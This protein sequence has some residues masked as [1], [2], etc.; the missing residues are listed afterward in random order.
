LH[1]RHVKLLR[2]ALLGLIVLVL[3][4]VSANYWES[5]RR[6]SRIITEA[7]KLLGANALRSADSIEYSQNEKGLVRFKI[8]A[9]RLLETREGKSYLEGIEAFDFKPDGSIQN[10]IRSRQARYDREHKQALFSGDVRIKMGE[11]LELQTETLHYDMQANL[12][13][14]EDRLRLTSSDIVGS[15]K[16]MRYQHQP[17]FLE[18]HSEIDFTLKRT[19]TAK[20]GSSKEENVR[21]TAARAGYSEADQRLHFQGNASLESETDLLSGEELVATLSPDRKRITS[22]LCRG[23][24]Q[25]QVKDPSETRR[26]KGDQ[27]AFAINSPSGAL[28]RIDVEGRAVFS[29]KSQDT[30]QELRGSEIHLEMDPELGIAR[31][32]RCRRSVQFHLGRGANQSR[33]EGENLQAA[34]FSG[35]NLMEHV[36]IWEHARLLTTNDSERGNDDL[37]AE[38]IRISFRNFEGRSV[39]SELQ[40]ERSVEWKTPPR[41]QRPG[42]GSEPGRSLT[43][44]FLKMLYDERG[45]TPDS[46]T[47]SGSV[48]VSG[49]PFGGS[50][51]QEIRRLQADGIQFRVFPG[52]NRLKFFEGSG[53]VRVFFQKPPDPATDAPAQEFNTSSNNIRATFSEKDGAA[54]TVSQWGNFRYED[55]SRSATSGRA[56]YQAAAEIMILREAPKIADAIGTTTGEVVEYDQKNRTLSVN[57]T[58]RTVL[59]P[60][61]GESRGPFAPSSNSA[62][63]SVVTAESMQYWSEDG[64]ARYSGNVQMLSENGQLQS[65]AL[66]ILEGGERVEGDGDVRHLVLRNSAGVQSGNA[67]EAA[68]RTRKKEKDSQVFIRSDRLRYIREQNSVHYAGNVSLKSEDASMSSESLDAVFDREGKQI[69]RAAARGRIS[70]RQS[71]RKVSGEFADY[72][73][74]PGKFVVTGR[75]AEITDPERGKSQAGRLTFFSTDDRILLENH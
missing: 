1:L 68:S 18:L 48:V 4:A 74:S 44:A 10:H 33:A 67:T 56:D 73:L 22:M 39:P 49:I 3:V 40:A 54:E 28:E 52:S 63:P 62:S 42:T 70:I 41:K 71:S 13:A 69:D 20:D 7:A 32:I 14:T 47:A 11:G 58:V 26:L 25:Y 21:V 2:R 57:K 34:F 6:R 59:R 55:Q 12:G 16:G 50:S 36:R 27:I 8:R 19:V 15:A 37:K 24:A 75:P 43:A 31:D 9:D 29:S 64:R 51:N 30:E 38:E 45:E 5:W 72:Y 17:K 66:E 60:Q 53:N 61:E 35:T 46:G 65:K 23:N